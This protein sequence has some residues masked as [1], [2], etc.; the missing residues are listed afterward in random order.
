M[1]EEPL[2]PAW[3]EQFAEQA[4]RQLTTSGP[5]A[6]IYP[7]MGLGRQHRERRAGGGGGQRHRIR[8]PGPG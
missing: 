3:S 8:S 6:Q 4:I 1:T 7:G 5:I 2:L